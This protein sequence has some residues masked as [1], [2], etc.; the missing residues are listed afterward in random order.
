M[1]PA[2]CGLLPCGLTAKPETAANVEAATIPGRYFEPSSEYVEKP[3][4]SSIAFAFPDESGKKLLI[5]DEV[6]KKETMT[7][8]LC[9]KNHLL[10]IKYL[11]HQDRNPIKDSGRQTHYNFANLKGEVFQIAGDPIGKDMNCLIAPKAFFQSRRMIQFKSAPG[12]EM[13]YGR[14]RPKCDEKTRD[15]IT[16]AKKRAITGCWLIG[17]IDKQGK[18]VAAVFEKKEG[19]LASL[20]LLGKNRLVS[21]DYPGDSG[22]RVDDEGEFQPT[23]EI[24]FVTRQEKTDEIEIGVSWPASEGNCLSVLRS[25]GNR[26]I[27]IKT[28]SFYWAPR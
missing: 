8:A 4:I 27:E 14:N 23:H 26:F 28:D 15:R 21:H 1:L 12:D 10:S 9:D 25:A 17:D 22:W 18:L 3:D 2:L 6:E 5:T 24:I 16:S 19:E 7:R 13:G 20:A 11:G